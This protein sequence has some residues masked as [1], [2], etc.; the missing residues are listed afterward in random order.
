M[1]KDTTIKRT[2]DKDPIAS[3]DLEDSHMTWSERDELKTL[4]KKY[5]HLFAH[6]ETQFPGTTAIKHVINVTDVTPL[7]QKA[8]RV[9]ASLRKALDDKLD[10]LLDAGIITPS[11]SPWASPLVLVKKPDNSIR[12]CV[13]Y[14]KLNA[15]TVAD[16][17]PL[18]RV[19]E[20]MECLSGAKYLT[21]LDLHSGFMHLLLCLF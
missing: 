10:T 9:P 17:Y 18:P 4:L 14:R 5:Q 20:S 11:C 19:D 21:T 1:P 3:L 15:V 12:P 7:R 2:P 8:Y 13:D 6:D 16:S